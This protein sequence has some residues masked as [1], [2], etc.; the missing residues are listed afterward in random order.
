MNSFVSSTD[1]SSCV[2]TPGPG[3]Q[4]RSPPGRHCG[5]VLGGLLKP[6]VLA[7][8]A[9]SMWRAPFL[10]GVLRLLVG[11]VPCLVRL[12]RSVAAYAALV[13]LRTDGGLL[14]IAASAA[15]SL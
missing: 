15:P 4:S 14:I 7:P 13:L 10:V 3:R 5:F 12:P 8:P 9:A 11:A 6:G 1:S 2:H